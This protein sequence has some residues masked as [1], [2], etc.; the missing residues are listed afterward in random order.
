MEKKGVTEES[1]QGGEV[2]RYRAISMDLSTGSEQ[3]RNASKTQA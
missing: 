2:Q 3:G 1:R